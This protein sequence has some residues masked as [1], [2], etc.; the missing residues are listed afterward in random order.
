MAQPGEPNTTPNR[1]TYQGI[2][3]TICRSC[4]EVIGSGKT[5]ATLL[6]VEEFHRC[7]AVSKEVDYDYG[8][9]IFEEKSGR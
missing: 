4:F 1:V 5:E 3:Y 9:R 6:A 7:S 8:R 2:T